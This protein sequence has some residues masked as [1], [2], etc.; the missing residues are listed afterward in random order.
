MYF[1]KSPG[2]SQASKRVFSSCVDQRFG[3]RSPYIDFLVDTIFV[4][5]GLVTLVCLASTTRLLVPEVVPK[6]DGDPQAHPEEDVIEP[7][8]RRMVGIGSVE[9]V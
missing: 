7:W 1:T 3:T 4:P 2:I 6:P 5:V 8:N 9:I